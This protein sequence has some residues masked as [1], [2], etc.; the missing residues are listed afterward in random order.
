M[1]LSGSYAGI[2]LACAMISE[3]LAANRPRMSDGGGAEDDL[4]MDEHGMFY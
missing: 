1:T 3:K 2:Q 4:L